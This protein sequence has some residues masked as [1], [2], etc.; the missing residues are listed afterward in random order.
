MPDEVVR[1]MPKTDSSL[2]PDAREI[3]TKSLKSGISGASAMFI[4]VLSL[5]WMRTTMNYQFK[6]GGGFLETL[7][8]L[9]AEGGIPRFYRGVAPALIIGPISRFGDTAANLFALTLFKSNPK[10]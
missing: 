1:K 10:L 6:N 9:Y 7:R 8:K 4:Q 2:P 5:M 3:V